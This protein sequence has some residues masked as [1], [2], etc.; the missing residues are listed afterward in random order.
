LEERLQKNIKPV[1]TCLETLKKV[2]YFKPVDIKKKLAGYLVCSLPVYELLS[3]AWTIPATVV[4][5]G[6]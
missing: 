2:L 3:N 1:S 4:T 6:Y 5:M